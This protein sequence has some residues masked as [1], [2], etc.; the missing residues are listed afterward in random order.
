MMLEILKLLLGITDNTQDD[1][2]SSLLVQS[3]SYVED[4]LDRKLDVDEYEDYATPNGSSSFPLRNYTVQQVFGIENLDGIAVEEF[5]LL[6]Q[7]GVVRTKQNLFG[8]YLITY[9]AGYDQLPGWAQKAI[10]DTAAAIYLDIQAGGSSVATGAIK[11]E[12]IV[13][14]AKVTYE[15]GTGSSSSAGGSDGNF[16][17]I[18]EPVINVLDM[19]KNRYA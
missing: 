1:V 14:V 13:G 7:P 18:P 2:L 17:S 3:Q 19:H 10:V 8:D 16:G 9:T 11:S 6:K 12:E 15:T 4:Y 5:K